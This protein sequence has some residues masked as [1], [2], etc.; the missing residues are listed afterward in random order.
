MNQNW[1]FMD[2][3]DTFIYGYPTL[4]Q[5]IADCFSR[6]DCHVE[7]DQVEAAIRNGMT[8]EDRGALRYQDQFERYLKNLY[9]HVLIAL[10]YP[11]N[12]D[13]ATD[14]LWAEWCSGHRLRLFDDAYA[15][16]SQL[17]ES[18]FRLGVIS[19]WDTTLIPVL[20]RLGVLPFFDV[21]VGSCDVH[22]AKP[23]PEIFTCALERAGTQAAGSW[24]LGDQL[25]MDILPARQLGFT[26]LY[27]DYHNKC[28][29]Q[30]V[31][32]YWVDSLRQGL[33]IILRGHPP[34]MLAKNEG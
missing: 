29:A 33:E 22:W 34:V 8:V 28:A 26:T 16:L 6:C 9:R 17:R 14:W 10:A 7:L 20:E 25:E 1:V 18:G 31:A 23:D 15:A 12:L 24:Y 4:Y 27:V 3:G 13:D 5:A 30:G 19:N 2:A 21:V 32:D 11:G